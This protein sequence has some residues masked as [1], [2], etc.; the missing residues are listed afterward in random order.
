MSYARLIGFVSLLLFSAV[1]AWD[2]A[3][4]LIIMKIALIE[5]TSEERTKLDT[6]L[7]GLQSGVSKFRT[8]EAACFQEDMEDLS[9][10]HICRCRR[11]AVCRS[12]WSPY[13]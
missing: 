6:I 12:R 8:V 4:H 1:K 9:L 11:Y 2:C 10:I 5:L 13:H 3:A 7:S